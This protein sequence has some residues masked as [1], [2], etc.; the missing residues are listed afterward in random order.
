MIQHGRRPRFSHEESAGMFVAVER[1]RQEFQGDGALQLR[2]Q[3]LVH[4]AHAAR[5]QFGDDLIAVD[6]LSDGGR[7]WST[8][9][10]HTK[11]K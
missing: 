2:I 6:R 8:R 9:R 11:S 7:P 10:R 1:R 3:R 5:T 4:H